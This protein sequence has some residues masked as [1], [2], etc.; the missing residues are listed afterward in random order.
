MRLLRS[1]LLAFFAVLIA[2]LVAAT[3][4]ALGAPG[5]QA[6]NLVKNPGF[7]TGAWDTGGFGWVPNN[8]EPWYGP[9]RPDYEL[10]THST[11]VHSGTYSARYHTA[12]QIHDAGLMQQITVTPGAKYRLT[13]YVLGWSTESPVVDTPS[14]STMELF[15]GIDPTG[16]RNRGGST[17]WASTRTL[18]KIVELTVE[19]V[20]QG[21]TITIFLRSRPD[22]PVARN[23]VF[24]DDVSVVQIEG[25][26][27][28]AQPTQAPSTGGTGTGTGGLATPD[29]NGRIVHTVAAGDTLSGLA[30]AYGVSM[31]QIKQL[32]G[33]TSNTIILGT[34]L[35]I[36]EG[37]A[38][39]TQAPTTAAPTQ[40][41]AEGS[42]APEETTPEPT[43]AP[44]EVAEVQNG[45]ICILG[46]LDA[47]SNGFREPEE[48]P[49]AGITFTLSDGSQAV[50]N[51]VT[52]GVSE[53]YC[54]QGLTAGTYL[55]SWAAENYTPT[56]D[57]TW[58]ASVSPGA[59][60]NREFGLQQAGAAAPEEPTTTQGGG[61]LPTWLL[62][63]I[64]AVGVVLLLAGV[65][66]GGYFLLLRRTKV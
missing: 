53:P 60:L 43:A 27:A 49:L 17:V 61:G 64:G 5:E 38:A 35:V 23:D 22:W 42:P 29:A 25:S 7:E 37:S 41:P 26:S 52:D 56:T 8:W 3:H 45:T 13:A 47:N 50:A 19:A 4:P 20:A 65:G 1:S 28:T 21:S 9:E 58:A 34:R 12:Y 24:W 51:Y 44:T 31:D 16:T 6:T 39:P 63:L 46:F 36:S 14:T 15:V 62:A 10:E 55:V 2:V 11:H 40:A 33:L 30:F 59:T 57:Q 32:N 48:Q 18:D 66:A 54:F